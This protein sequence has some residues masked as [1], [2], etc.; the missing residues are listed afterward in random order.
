MKKTTVK[1]KICEAVLDLLGK[2]SLAE[3]RISELTDK[4]G[5]ARASFY[6]NFESFD[7][8]I[9]YIAEDYLISF[10]ELIKPLL[11]EKN[12]DAWYGEVHKVLTNIYEKRQNFTNVLSDNLR[13]IFNR[14]EEMDKVISSGCLDTTPYIRYE[15]LAKISAFYSVCMN[16]VKHGA[17]ESIDDMTLFMLDKVLCITQQ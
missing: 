10:S 6:R 8:V 12:Y 5:V 4:A 16:W 3:I 15:H 14:M 2:E 13:F 9:D 7:Q 1:N 17:V 11:I